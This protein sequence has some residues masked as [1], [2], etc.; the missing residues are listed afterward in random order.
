[1]TVH[2]ANQYGNSRAVPVLLLPPKLGGISPGGTFWF[3]SAVTVLGG[4]WVWFFVPETGGR[5]LES[6][7]RLFELPWHRIGRYGNDDADRLDVAI[8]E[9]QTDMLGGAAE[10]VDVAERTR[11]SR[12]V[13]V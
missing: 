6:M 4:V 9:K 7:N 10:H 8:G 12:E 1:M 11:T 13:R 5:S 2:F 3:F